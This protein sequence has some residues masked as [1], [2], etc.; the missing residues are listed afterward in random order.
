MTEN[1]YRLKCEMISAISSFFLT[2]FSL[3]VT[4]P[5]ERPLTSISPCSPT[6]IIIPSAYTPSSGLRSRMRLPSN[7]ASTPC[8]FKVFDATRSA[9]KNSFKNMLAACWRARRSASSLLRLAS[10]SATAL[11]SADMKLS[12]RPTP[13]STDRAFEADRDQLLRFDRELH[14]ELLEHVLDEAVDHERHRLLGRKAALAAVEQHLLGNL[15]GR[16]LVLEH[17]GGVLRLDIGHGVGAA[18]IADQERVAVGEVP[19][20]L[21]AAVR[22]HLAAV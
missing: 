15:R 7:A 20:A 5:S 22:H 1:S 12:P 10:S 2:S 11:S 13:G 4:G 9:S 8:S 17:R 16:R 14:R 3:A 21:G 19:R 6:T 18:L